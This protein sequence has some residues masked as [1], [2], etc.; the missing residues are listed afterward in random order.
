MLVNSFTATATIRR[1]TFRL[2]RDFKTLLLIRTSAYGVAGALAT[3]CPE[4]VSVI[5][6]DH[7]GNRVDMVNR[8]QLG[9]M[10][11]YKQLGEGAIYEQYDGSLASNL[12]FVS[13]LP[14]VLTGDAG[15][16]VTGEDQ[17]NFELE[18]A[19]I[20]ATYDLHLFETP[21]F[22]SNFLEYTA[23]TNLAGSKR[24]SLD[25][26]N[27][28]GL[29]IPTAAPIDRIILRYGHGGTRET[30]LEELRQLNGEM[31]DIE[32][33][34]K[35]LAGGGMITNIFGSEESQYVFL[36]C[37]NVTHVD[38][39]SDGSQFEITQIGVAAF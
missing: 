10:A 9:A 12:H 32:S 4:R 2:E 36:D 27:L 8:I 14:L 3:G 16:H 26:D 31:N 1:T 7:S 17:V 23:V 6:T 38:F 39:D 35:T 28:V 33:R 21:F 29:V 24:K 19:I 11:F 25:V 13:N 37:G 34:L 22:G 15:I 30:S 5:K 18:D 20:G